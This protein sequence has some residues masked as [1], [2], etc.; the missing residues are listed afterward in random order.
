MKYQCKCSPLSAFHWRDPD[1]PRL[2][3]WSDLNR[4]QVSSAHS[5]AVVNAKRATGV[6]VATVHGLSNKQ[7]PMKLDPRHFHVFMKAVTSD[8]KNKRAK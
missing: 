8:G 5:S 7:H 4:T 3:D 2:I 1:R 6:D